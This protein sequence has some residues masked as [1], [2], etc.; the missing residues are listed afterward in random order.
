[1]I[2]LRDEAGEDKDVALLGMPA[3]SDWVLFAAYYS[4]RS[5]LRNA[6]WY[7]L[8]AQTGN[9]AVRTRYVEVFSNHEGGPLD[10]D[11]YMGV[12][13]LMETMKVDADRVDIENIV[14]T[15]NSAPDITGG[16]IFKIDREL[17]AE[18]AHWH[19]S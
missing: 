4:E 11:D 3:E 7:D 16:F 9:Y 8:S 13:S 19:S 14:P 12:Y 2:E 6:L 17:S 10:A 18:D 1:R 5:L 15:D